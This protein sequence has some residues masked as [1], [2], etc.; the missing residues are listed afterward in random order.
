M[1]DPI[2]AFDQ[3]RANFLLY[4]KTAFGT[5]FPGLELER[6]KLLQD[7]SLNVFSREP[8]IE[9]LPRYA[10]SGKTI[11]DLA[12]ED[13]PG[14]QEQA[15][16]DF[17]GLASA[18]LVG[19]FELHQHQ[20][21][22]LRKSL[23]GQ[24][25]VITSGTGS[26]K[27]ESFLLPLFTY[28]AQESQDWRAP[29]E[30]QAHWGDWWSSAE[31]HNECNPLV[32][33]KHRMQRSYRVSQRG[34]ET[35]EAA[36]RALILYPMNAL[37]EDQLTRLRRALDSDPA[38]NWF[39]EHR[40]GNYVYFGRYNGGTPVAGHEY[41]KPSSDGTRGPNSGK[42]KELA[43]E[44]TLAGRAA[45]Y[46]ERYAIENND[47]DVRFY[48]PSLDGAEMRSR[49]D[50][51]ECP[52]DI[53]ITNYSMLSIM[54]MREADENIFEQTR[55]W[56]ERYGSVFHLII[57]ELHLY[58]GTAGTEVA[59]LLKL[60]LHR[61][62]LTPAS[63]KLR[64]LASSAS[65][66]RDDPESL[67]FLSD[68]F[69]S[70]WLAEQIVPGYPKPL[71]RLSS[72][73]SLPFEPFARLA[74]CHDSPVEEERNGAL[75]A[76]AIALGGG[77]NATSSQERLRQ[78]MESQANLVSGT[79]LQACTETVDGVQQVR[80]ISL[81]EFSAKVFP[82]A[83]SDHDAKKATRGLL[84]ARNLCDVAGQDSALPSFRLHWFFRNIEGLWACT[85][86]N[87]QCSAGEL[88]GART[89]GRLFPQNRIMCGAGEPHRVLE[90]LYCEQ[91]GTTFFGGSR[92]SLPDNGDVELLST[93]PDIEGI[94]DRQAAR[95]VERR[96]YN[97]FA[98]FWPSGV[99]SINPEA[100]QW[101]QPSP[102][103]GQASTAAR[104]AAAWLDT[105]SAR[106]FLGAKQPPAEAGS[107]TAGFLFDL[108]KVADEDKDKYSTLPA[109]CPR[110]AA[111]YRRR[112][113]RSPVRGFRTGFSKVSQL[114]AKELFY[115]LP[116]S[117]PKLVVFSD[118]R[119]DAASISNG[120]ERSH[121]SDLVRE[122]MYDELSRM[123]IGEASLVEDLERI[124]APGRK[125]AVLY[126]QS[127]PAAVSGLLAVIKS[128]QKT[129]PEGLDEEDREVL[130][131]KRN[132]ARDVL[133]V[134]RERAR[135]RTVPV[136]ILFEPADGAANP[137]GIGLLVRRLKRLGVNPA[138]NDVLYQDY[139][140]DGTN[141][142]WTEFFEF[143]VQGAGWKVG[144]SP[145]AVARREATL[146]TK[147]RAE[148]C[149]VLFSRNYFGFEASGLGYARLDLSQER[150]AELAAQCGAS[151]ELLADICTGALRVLGDMYRYP[152][153]PDD[154]PV[155]SWPD[156][157]SVTRPA[158]PKYL[159]RCAEAN[160]IR[161]DQLLNAVWHAL[162]L[163]GG[164]SNLVINPRRL[165]VRVA[166]GND[167]VWICRSCRRPHL[168]NS[169][170]IC[171]RCR[172]DL[173]AQPT[174]NCS[175]LH[176]RNY[177]AQEAVEL[178]Q[179]LRLHSEELTAQTDNQPERQRHFRGIVLNLDQE[180]DRQYIT[181][182]DEIDILSVTTTME[183]GIDIGSL[184]A[185]M[186][187]NMP[188]MR[189]N[190]QQRVG[191]AGRRGQ[192]FAV[193]LTLCR[194]R[195]HDEF[196]YNHPRRI[197]GDRP[198]VP[199]L[200]MGQLQIVQR[201]MA[202]ETLRQ[203]F[204]AAG[205]RWWDMPSPPDSHGEFGPVSDW[206]AQEGRRI[207]VEN[208]LKDSPN[209][210][211]IAEALATG[212]PAEVSVTSLEAFA[213]QDLIA[214]VHE[215]LRNPELTGDGLA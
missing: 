73:Q 33:T 99:A 64:I 126:A 15:L 76:L 162:A 101:Q 185:V 128:A 86:P 190:Y 138:G 53:L 204:R 137:S 166:T 152:Q 6:E 52:P 9:P 40:Q 38:R 13:L 167:P 116:E 8:W 132:Q 161:E 117:K 120:I 187:A 94:P 85:G 203:A 46:A 169:G 110:C 70:P 168:H 39:A 205:V 195:S 79:M 208:W 107:W 199:F 97:D 171:T 41:N 153:E 160:H 102:V 212:T 114:L 173:E 21:E 26:G 4:I 182:V 56:L 159:Q 158:L 7:P 170:G 157:A 149:D 34:H 142:H 22:M 165:L 44:L 163:D 136:R 31:W 177:Y 88:D 58:R 115:L 42:I 211:S 71:P 201:L 129:I 174:T 61:L 50:M 100:A 122:A 32:G 89:A 45:A 2:A 146:L 119:E 198:P 1:Q 176:E 68:F 180:Q 144:L 24:N 23:S 123:A 60:L 172:A 55:K 105:T 134:I 37:V 145:E 10:G 188:P 147:V 213:R 183:V 62:G 154:P 209:V 30:K 36:V 210:S 191:R 164:H 141:H 49:W 67:S 75:D 186:Q 131:R 20:L 151:P 77:E 143:D 130:E 193:V 5:Q 91:C 66:E 17:K 47:N 181:D 179:P 156:W 133:E 113:R 108:P 18:G 11:R 92:Y 109:F 124:G 28:L 69:G 51:Q 65:L 93:D 57:D 178:R 189:F 135:A 90:L 104:W 35:R 16:A 106:V 112:R 103:E 118:S 72:G 184:R 63:P 87:C 43:K 214:N 140:Y 82:A 148:V 197:T 121:Y 14:L 139:K 48:F 78:A 175:Y 125:E 215:A 84:I 83:P 96:S 200:S 81:P 80:A 206:L 192:A 29:L 207:S 19:N 194:G 25:C 74:D 12:V 59:Y 155:E 95:F 202:K 54:L 196:Y 150:L 3:V 111:D 127:D 98:I 27:T